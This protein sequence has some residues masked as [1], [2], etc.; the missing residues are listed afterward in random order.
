MVQKAAEG[1]RD[2]RSV[3]AEQGCS[4]RELTSNKLIW[5]LKLQNSTAC[6]SRGVEVFP[7]LGYN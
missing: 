3:N 2:V 4:H 6:S 1:K 7:Y 5:S